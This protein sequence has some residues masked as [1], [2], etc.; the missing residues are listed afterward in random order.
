MVLNYFEQQDNN[1]QSSKQLPS[2]L[3]NDNFSYPAWKYTEELRILKAD[4]IKQH[5]KAA[6]FVVKRNYQIRGADIAA[7]LKINRSSLM[8]TSS[9][10]KKFRQYLDEVNIDLMKQK[11]S[12]IQQS[13]NHPSRG[14]IESSKNQLLEANIKLK[15]QVDE[16][17]S[18]NIKELVERTFDQLPL[19]L[20]RKLGLD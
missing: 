15:K 16:L 10:S 5:H 12:R 3:S 9:F 19:P 2:W 17:Q 13:R 7:H 18:Q 6:D 14:S 1:P 11:E 4:Y 20:K 8:N